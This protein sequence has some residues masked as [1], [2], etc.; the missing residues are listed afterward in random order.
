MKTI[1]NTSFQQGVGKTTLT[2]LLASYLGHSKAMSV[3]VGDYD[4]KNED[5]KNTMTDYCKQDS[6]RGF[7]C[8]PFST[9]TKEDLDGVDL[10]IIDLPYAPDKDLLKALDTK[11]NGALLPITIEEK[12]FNAGAKPAIKAM[13]G[14]S[15]RFVVQNTVNA[16]KIS[17]TRRDINCYSRALDIPVICEMPD[18]GAASEVVTKGLAPHYA[19]DVAEIDALRDASSKFGDKVMEWL[20]TI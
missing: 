20:A 9:L 16:S 10:L 17:G 14:C 15:K 11:I 6:P 12:S 7:A 5:G 8:K 4:D 18:L 3:M 13:N 19:H 1:I 2:Y